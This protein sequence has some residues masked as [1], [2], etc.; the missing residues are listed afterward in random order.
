MEIIGDDTCRVTLETTRPNRS[1]LV[2]DLVFGLLCALAFAKAVH[3]TADLRW[4]YDLD[5]FREI[6]M[7]QAVLDHRFGSDQLYAGEKIWYNPLSSTVLAAISYVTSVP[8]ALVVSRAG[9]YLN[10]L[11][12][13]AFYILVVYLFDRRVALA[14]AAAFLFA[15]I[16][17]APAWATPTYSPWVFSQNLT[18]GFFYL[19][20]VSYGKSLNAVGWRWHLIS[21]ALLGIIFL[22]HT[23]P[24]VIL[25][26]IMLFTSVVNPTAKRF[27]GFAIILAIAFLF[28]LPFSSSIL[29][30]YHLKVLNSVP[31]N[32]MYPSLMISELM[33]FLRSYVSWIFFF[34]AVG[35]GALI[36]CKWSGRLRAIAPTSFDRNSRTVLLIWIAI[37]CAALVVN[38]IQQIPSPQWHLMFVPAH[39]FL[40]YLTAAEYILFGLGFVFACH[41]VAQKFLPANRAVFAEAS[42]FG[43]GLLVFLFC[44]RGAYANRFDFTNARSQAITFQERKAYIDAYRWILANTEPADV[45]LSL[46]G[47]LDLSIVGPADRK[48][49]VACQAEFSNPYVDWKS[50]SETATKV[51]DKLAAGA[52]DALA[53][54]RENHIDYLITAPISFLDDRQFSYLTKTFA[55]DEVTI[56]RVGAPTQR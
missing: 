41:F 35:L 26:L 33:N 55:E 49:M 22:G 38:E 56:Y 40:F 25:G 17:D 4:P 6:G 36:I 15:P 7:A 32:W 30:H 45:F 3:T 28:S 44:I 37:C 8:I 43:I 23:A 5:Q 13:I 18:Q 48:V 50:R 29:F 16:G 54:L 53:D 42:L 20:L 51:V 11:A 39:H 27:Q 10:L 34:A 14:A 9:P 1:R 52:P 24:A 47:D 21:G 12:P 46:T 2:Y 31:G 19:G